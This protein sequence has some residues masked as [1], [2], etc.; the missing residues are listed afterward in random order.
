MGKTVAKEAANS[1]LKGTGLELGGKS[2]VFVLGVPSG[3]SLADVA[4][5]AH[6]A[7]FWNS[8]QCC[9]AGSRTYVAVSPRLDDLLCFTTVFF[10]K[11]ELF[12]EFVRLSVDLAKAKVLGDPFNSSTTM[13]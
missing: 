2:P 6:H 8:G 12:D 7:M 13:V 10:L 4:L 9:S 3:A 5:T 11:D 1:N